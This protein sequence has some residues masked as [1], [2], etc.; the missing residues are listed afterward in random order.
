MP[1]TQPQTFIY[2]G[3]FITLG[4]FLKVENLAGSGGEAKMLLASGGILVNGTSETRRG[5]KLR[6]GD[7]VQFGRDTWQLLSKEQSL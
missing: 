4:Q 1:A 2:D 6:Q 5:R 7:R 3:D